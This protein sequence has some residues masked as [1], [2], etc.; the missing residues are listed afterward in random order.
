MIAVCLAWLQLIS[1]FI[2]ECTIRYCEA[3]VWVHPVFCSVATLTL[4]G[5]KMA[6]LWACVMKQCV[7]LIG[8]IAWLIGSP[9]PSVLYRVGFSEKKWLVQNT[10]V[11]WLLLY[12]LKQQIP[13]LRVCYHGCL[14]T[15]VCFVWR[16]WTPCDCVTTE[17]FQA[18]LR[19]MCDVAAMW[20]GGNKVCDVGGEV[21]RR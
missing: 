20:W 6:T 21:V 15:A 10:A 2:S 14:C 5:D 7:T 12:R 4:W 8:W 16:L 9:E 19:L 11:I 3:F 18:Q 13:L 1:L 17:P